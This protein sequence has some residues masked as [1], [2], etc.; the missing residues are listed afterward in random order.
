MS[1]EMAY[2]KGCTNEDKVRKIGRYLDQVN[3]KW[4]NKTKVM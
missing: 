2:G 1:K 4:F 3:Y